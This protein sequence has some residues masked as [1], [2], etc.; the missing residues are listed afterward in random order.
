MTAPQ[1]LQSWPGL[2][3]PSIPNAFYVGSGGP[4]RLDSRLKGGNDAGAGGPAG[5]ACR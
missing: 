5:E 1:P 3:R 4:S 2:T